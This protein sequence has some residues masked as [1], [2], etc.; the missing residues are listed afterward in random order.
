MP[1]MSGIW[2]KTLGTASDWLPPLWLPERDDLMT[3]IR[4]PNRAPSLQEDDLVVLQGQA[5]GNRPLL[6]PG[7]DVGEIVAGRQWPMQVLGVARLLTEA[8]VVIGQEAVG[9]RRGPCF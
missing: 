3:A 4:F 5:V 1:I 2:L 8:S 6:A 7:E 9:R